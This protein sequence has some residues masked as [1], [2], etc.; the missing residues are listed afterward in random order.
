MIRL[1]Y[2]TGCAE[3]CKYGLIDS[4]WSF[5]FLATLW[6]ALWYYWSEIYPIHPIPHLDSSVLNYCE[7]MPALHIW[8]A[9][10]ISQFWPN[11]T[12]LTCSNRFSLQPRKAVSLSSSSLTLAMLTIAEDLHKSYWQG[13][14][15]FMETNFFKAKNGKSTCILC[16][17]PCLL[18]M[19]LNFH[20]Y[21]N[22]WAKSSWGPLG[23]HQGLVWASRK[24]TYHLS[25][26]LGRGSFICLPYVICLQNYQNSHQRRA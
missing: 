18:R 14:S 9:G 26:A 5:Y 12:I 24:D 6:G 20:G 23:T 17:V 13:S 22:H 7:I 11:F 16:I 3:R 25:W 10:I 8:K 15:E 19:W 2:L 1:R 4:H 21:W